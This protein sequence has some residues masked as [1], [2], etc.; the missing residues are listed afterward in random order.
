MPWKETCHVHERMLFVRLEKGERM[1][2]LRREFVQVVVVA[3]AVAV[4]VNVNV[5]VNVHDHDFGR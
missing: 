2:D 5:N 3:V 1:T 4:N